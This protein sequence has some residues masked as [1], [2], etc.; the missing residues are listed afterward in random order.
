MSSINLLISKTGVYQNAIPT[1]INS[2]IN[3]GVASSTSYACQ[4][5]LEFY[6][7]IIQKSN[8]LYV[9]DI[10]SIVTTGLTGNVIVNIYATKNSPYPVTLSNGNT[11]NVATTNIMQWAGIVSKILFTGTNVT[12]CNYINVIFDKNNSGV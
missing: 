8:G 6:N 7:N 11:I 10:N 1:L 3:T 12:G 4:I 5:S 2:E 9:P